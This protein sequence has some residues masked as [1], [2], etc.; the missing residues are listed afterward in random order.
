MLSGLD[1]ASAVPR[2]RKRARNMPAA[3]ESLTRAKQLARSTAQTKKPPRRS[4]SFV[5]REGL[6]PRSLARFTHFVLS[7]RKCRWTQL[8][9]SAPQVAAARN[10]AP[11]VRISHSCFWNEK[12][13]SRGCFR[14]KVRRE[15][16]F[17]YGNGTCVASHFVLVPRTRYDMLHIFSSLTRGAQAPRSGAHTY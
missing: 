16:F 6:I 7:S 10:M 4:F 8:A 11:L 15:G 3:F 9:C 12:H 2:A 14:Q 5:R 1:P 17:P 13:P